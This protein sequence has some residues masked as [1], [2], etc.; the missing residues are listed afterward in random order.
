[1]DNVYSNSDIL[2]SNLKETQEAA[3]FK[4]THVYSNTIGE[5]P[6]A[7][8][9]TADGQY[10]E[11]RGA[12]CRYLLAL[13][14]VLCIALLGGLIAL[15]VLYMKN[16]SRSDFLEEENSNLFVSLSAVKQR[17]VGTEIKLEDLRLRHADVSG[18]LS[19]LREIQRKFEELQAKHGEL[20]KTISNY[21][22]DCMCLTGWKMH[23]GKCYYFSTEK[24]NWFR[25]QE[26]CVSKGA[27][28]VII[29]NQQKQNFVSSNIRETHWMGLSDQETEGQ[30]LWV[31]NTPLNKSGA[32]Y[33]WNKEP[34]NWTGGGNPA[35]EDCASLGDHN[36]NINSWSDASCETIKKF[37]CEK[38]SLEFELLRF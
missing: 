38:H 11:K 5:E 16:S 33:W 22:G 1:M 28:L 27:H 37:V 31:D 14:A 18:T 20:L 25:S 23:Q 29:K 35:G 10:A 13:L 21:C 15:G 17:L 24:M 26:Y 8:Q 7:E 9:S 32:Q 12:R 30:W 34:D 3:F 2:F 36:G 6:G 19:A 4:D